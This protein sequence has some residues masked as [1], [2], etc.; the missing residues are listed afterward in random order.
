VERRGFEKRQAGMAF[1]LALFIHFSG[2]LALATFSGGRVEVKLEPKLC[3]GI[4]CMED[5]RISKRRGADE[6]EADLGIIEAS[7]VPRLGLKEEQRGYPKLQKYEQPQRIEEAVNVSNE[8]KEKRD[9]PMK[10]A[11][12]KPAEIDKQRKTKDLSAILGAPED[13]DPRKR[14]TALE[15]IVGSPDGSVYGVG[16]TEM[17]GNIYAGKVA[18]AIREVFVVPPFLSERELKTL[19]MRIRVTKIN[20][21]GEILGFEIEMESSNQAFDAACVRAI[22]E[23]VPKEGGKRHL[24]A[25]DATTLSYINSKGMVVDLDG[26]L[27]GK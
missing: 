16:A 8:I 6:I 24:P 4:R 21:A 25:P 14:P 2:G 17:K 12:A 7:V 22:K 5:A 11:K 13:D 23:F 9:V 27:F 3:D 1:F 19:K 15:K 26:A 18:L 20:E 10:D